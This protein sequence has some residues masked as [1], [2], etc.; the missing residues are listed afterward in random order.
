MKMTNSVNSRVRLGTLLI[1]LFLFCFTYKITMLPSRV[2]R[3]SAKASR[4][5][6]RPRQQPASGLPRPSRRSARGA[7][8][9][10]PAA[11]T[12]LARTQAP[13]IEHSLSPNG[14]GRVRIRH[15][16]YIQDISG[17][18]AFAN[19]QLNINPGISTT[20]PWLSQIARNYESYLFN[21]CEFQF[22]TQKSSSTNGSLM[23]AVDFDAADSAPTSK[24][25][26]MSYHN[27]VRSAVWAECVNHSDK[28]DLAKFGVQRYNRFA[29][30]AANLDIKTY[31]V[32]NINV[33]TQGCADTS[34]IGE[35]YV[36]YDVEF[37]TP[38]TPSA[39]TTDAGQKLVGVSGTKDTA[40][41]G[42]TPTPTGTAYFTATNNTF[43]CAVAGQ[44]MFARSLTV[45]GGGA[46]VTGASPTGTA[47]LTWPLGALYSPAAAA[48]WIDVFIVT[49]TVGQ[50]VVF[51]DTATG[52]WNAS[53]V[54]ITPYLYSLA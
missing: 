44:Y 51:N 30:L 3:P 14:D 45:S 33:A 21:K 27:A 19:T 41:M 52:T 24:T 42:T 18:V 16:E 32:G 15:R 1:F 46:V 29:A 54:R 25:E 9:T 2:Q 8:I 40:W 50:T 11:T 7:E 10:V 49:A 22:E 38:Q 4:R 23:M 34:A 20:F 26:I 39:S 35:L 28:Q 43:T 37:M 5:G 13:Q 48:T 6:R 31:D 36:D 47:T 53:V 17:S 12:R